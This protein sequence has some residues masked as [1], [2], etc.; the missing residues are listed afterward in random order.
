MTI[1]SAPIVPGKTLLKN[2]QSA[3]VSTFGGWPLIIAM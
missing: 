1:P 3:W 2:W